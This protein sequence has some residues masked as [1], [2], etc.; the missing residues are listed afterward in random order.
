MT[1]AIIAL[2]MMV[3]TILPVMNH[4]AS[5]EMGME[6]VTVTMEINPVDMGTH[7]LEVLAVV[8][9]DPVR[10]DPEVHLAAAVAVVVA[11]VAVVMVVPV[12]P[13]PTGHLRPNDS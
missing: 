9:P 10:L 5:P 6:T 8:R 2:I 4:P 3:T 12:H 1:I 11:E 13:G 7:L